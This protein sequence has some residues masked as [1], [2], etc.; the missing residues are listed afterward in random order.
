MTN[1]EWIA[2][3]TA[4][5]VASVTAVLGGCAALGGLLRVLGVG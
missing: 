1:R 2:L 4:G 5:F 3:Q